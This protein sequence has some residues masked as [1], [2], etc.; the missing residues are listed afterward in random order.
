[1]TKYRLKSVVKFLLP[2]TFDM[3]ANLDSFEKYRGIY[4]ARLYKAQVAL[5][6]TFDADDLAA[7]QGLDI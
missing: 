5:K 7:L 2:S 4:R 6:G 3:S 1:M